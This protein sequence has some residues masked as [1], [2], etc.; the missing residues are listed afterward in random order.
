MKKLFISMLGLVCSLSLMA[1]Q[2]AY[3]QI[4]I[5]GTTYPAYST[6]SLYLTEDSER[7]ASYE[8]GYDSQ[9]MGTL[10]NDYSVLIYGFVGS[11]K[12]SSVATDDLT[13]LEIG[14]TTNNVDTEYKLQ[15]FDFDGQEFILYDRLL[16]TSTVI[17]AST[18]DYPFTAAAGRVEVNDR[19]VI[20]VPAAYTVTPKGSGYASFSATEATVIPA[21]VTVYKAEYD[22]VSV[23]TLT[24][25]ADYIPANTGVIVAGTADLDYSFAVV[26]DPAAVMPDMSGNNLKPSTAFDGTGEIYCL[27]HVGSESAF[28]QYTGATMPANK[29]FLKLV[30]GAAAAPKRI[31]MRFNGAT[32]ID[33]VEAESVKA[34]KF[35]E[36]GQI[37]I[38]RGNEVFNLQGQQLR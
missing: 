29:A 9:D 11:T 36:N 14:F 20:G 28:Y 19:F 5:V 32:A 25:I 6:N 10:S 8:S 3:V 38:R 24:A 21:G 22:G 18:P 23:L 35:V 1:T 31:T 13:G 17:N 7:N 4:D 12:C 37:L 26:T 27:R 16:H 15:F 34:E 2:T 33:N 30:G